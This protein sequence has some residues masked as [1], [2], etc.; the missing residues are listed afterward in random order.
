MKA[1][2]IQFKGNSPFATQAKI[3]FHMDRVNDWK[4]QGCYSSRPLAVEINLT[5]YCNLDCQWCIS[6]NYIKKTS[7]DKEKLFDFLSDFKALGGKSITLSGGGEPTTYPFF[8]EIVEKAVSLKLNIGL[9]TNGVFSPKL[10]KVIGENLTWVRVSLDT[11]NKEKYKQWKGLDCVDIV[12]DHIERLSEY[13]VKL[14]VNCNVSAGMDV[15]DIVDFIAATKELDVDYIQFR[16]ILPRYYMEETI[17]INQPVWDF[18]QEK[19]LHDPIMAFSFDKLADLSNG[20]S[21]FPYKSCEGHFFSFVLDSNGDVNVCMYHT[22]NDKFIMGNINTSSFVDIWL[23]AKRRLVADNCRNLDFESECQVC[24]KLHELNKFLEF[25][26]NPDKSMD[27][28]FL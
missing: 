3:L 16:P 27:I 10:L 21:K 25:Y 7:Q 24:C 28:N 14:G 8:T 5:D 22:E 1:N 26:M 18:L 2:L 17:E 6:S 4:I 12:L 19:Y 20:S 13:P 11:V 9:M 23:G 15:N